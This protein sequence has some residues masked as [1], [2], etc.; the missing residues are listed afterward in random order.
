MRITPQTDL[1]SIVLAGTFSPKMFHPL[2]FSARELIGMQEAEN[3]R[4]GLLHEQITNFSTGKLN[5][6]VQTERFA[7]SSTILPDA[8]R[9]LVLGTFG[10]HLPGTPLRAMGINRTVHFDT[11]S[12]TARNKV[13]M[14]LAP[15]DA[16]GDWGKSLAA[17]DGTDRQGGLLS[18]KMQQTRADG[19]P[20][21]YVQAHVEPSGQIR[22]TGI[23]MEIN[24][25]YTITKGP[26]EA[27]DASEILGLLSSEWERANA[28]AESII[29]Q[30]MS[31]VPTEA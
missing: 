3:A 15:R 28:C 27:A 24:N 22:G 30:I 5:I 26:V 7:A 14:R 8:P 23:F 9:D 29:D 20:A 2:W 18:L 12:A 13:S 1:R 6:E 4:I 10:Q 19:E 16:W 25:H 31:L 21:G 11:G 17:G